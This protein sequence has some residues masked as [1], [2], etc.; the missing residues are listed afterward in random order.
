MSTSRLQA[1]GWELLRVRGRA[2]QLHAWS[3]E[4]VSA[5]ASPSRRVVRA[6]PDAPAVVLGSAQDP[7]SLDADAV[8]AAG[9]EVARRK[10]GGG[11]VLVGGQHCLWVDFVIPVEDPLWSKDVSRAG[12][13]VGEVLAKALRLAGA[14]PAQVWEGPTLRASW[15]RHVCFAGLA[16]G[17]VTL[18]ARKVVGVSARRTRVGALFQTAT[19]VSWQPELLAG[20]LAVQ[21]PPWGGKDALGGLAEGVGVDRAE[22]VWDALARALGP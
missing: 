19:L 15:G 2:S 21:Q 9:L 10:S 13:W 16:P 5:D 18:G 3:A 20:L 1:G 12:L 7:A 8:A 11:A 22:R 6:E 14:G 4:M 17:E